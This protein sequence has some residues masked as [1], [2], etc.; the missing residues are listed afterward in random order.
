MP[1]GL[2]L[3]MGECICWSESGGVVEFSFFKYR[4]Y[5]VLRY[6]RIILG[7]KGNGR[8]RKERGK[9]WEVLWDW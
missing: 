5:G 8:K 9:E 6:H 7:G 1:E 4:L 3:L 2:M